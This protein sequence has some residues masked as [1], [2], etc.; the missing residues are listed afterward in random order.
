VQQHA[1]ST[2]SIVL[3]LL[4]MLL[5]L[6]P[7]CRHP[8]LQ[9]PPT[10]LLLLSMPQLLLCGMGVFQPTAHDVTSICYCCCC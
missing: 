1:T 8:A 10:P 7:S 5:L 2:C 4:L 3:V 6:N 9:L